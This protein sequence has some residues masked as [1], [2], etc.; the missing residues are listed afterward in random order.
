[1]ATTK[2]SEILRVFVSS[3]YEDMAVYR[4]AAMSALT[5]IEQLPVGMEHFVS[6]PEKSLDVCL[7]EVRRCQ[8]FI[9]LVGMRYGSI[10]KDTGKSYSE[11]EYEEAIKNGIPVLAFIIDENECPI[12]PK[13]VDTGENAQ[14]LKDFKSV[15]NVKYTSRFKSVDNIKELISRAVKKHV[16]DSA[17]EKVSETRKKAADEYKAG[18]EIFKR[19]L[20]LPGRYKN[21]EVYLRVRLNNSFSTWIVK[22]TI[23]ISRRLNRDDTIHSDDGAHVIGC[24]FSDIGKPGRA[25]DLFAEGK[26][27]DWLLDNNVSRGMVFEGTFKLSYE[28]ISGVSSDGKRI[29]VAALILVNGSSIIG[30]DTEYL[31]SLRNEDENDSDDDGRQ[32]AAIAKTLGLQ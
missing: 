21:Q 19:F 18:A 16:D 2:K 3:T 4:E 13:F 15:L 5:S 23:F 9:A 7:S 6:S 17:T 12:I 28:E 29:S 22:D 30:K 10:D 31:A 11:L 1:M 27:A 14:K 26:N 20:I 32:L 8:L 25:V 24:D